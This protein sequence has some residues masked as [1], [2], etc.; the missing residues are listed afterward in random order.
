MEAIVS[1]VRAITLAEGSAELCFEEVSQFVAV[2][3]KAACDAAMISKDRVAVVVFGGATF[4][5]EID[6]TDQ[7][8]TQVREFFVIVCDRAMGFNGMTKALM[9]DDKTIGAY[10]LADRLMEKLCGI[11]LVNPKGIRIEPTEFTDLAMKDE[12]KKNLPGRGGVSLA[13]NAVGGLMSKPLGN[14]P[15]Q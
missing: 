15:I 14:G 8:T 12:V 7:V 11:L 13:F 5:T 2:D 4:K 6:G 1:K 9:G 3:I 10:T